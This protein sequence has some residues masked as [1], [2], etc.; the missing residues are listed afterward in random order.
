MVFTSLAFVI[1]LYYILT[2]SRR[3]GFLTILRAINSHSSFSGNS[4][5]NINDILEYVI[6][7]VPYEVNNFS[8]PMSRRG[9]NKQKTF[10]FCFTGYVNSGTVRYTAE[11][12]PHK[13]NCRQKDKSLVCTRAPQHLE[14]HSFQ[15]VHTLCFYIG[16]ASGISYIQCLRK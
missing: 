2:V 6:D 4:F 14:A 11:N 16:L 5:G 7:N 10:F 9:H 3:M 12:R 1:A 13:N 15:R 8:F